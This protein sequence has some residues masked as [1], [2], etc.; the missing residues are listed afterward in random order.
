MGQ[1]SSKKDFKL[2]N[3]KGISIEPTGSIKKRIEAADVVVFPSGM[4]KS[5]SRTLVTPK[6]QP[7]QVVA[8]AENSVAMTTDQPEAQ[9]NNEVVPTVVSSVDLISLFYSFPMSVFVLTRL[10]QFSRP[11]FFFLILK[12]QW[13]TLSIV[14]HVYMK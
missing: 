8:I 6:Q 13:Q 4:P 2:E 1:S 10:Y 3:S 9:S 12:C 11:L 14:T 7:A 5:S